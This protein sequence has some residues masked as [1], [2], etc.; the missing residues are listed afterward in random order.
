MN[1]NFICYY[2]GGISMYYNFRECYLFYVILEI[3]YFW[4]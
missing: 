3:I 2:L 1:N 4:Y